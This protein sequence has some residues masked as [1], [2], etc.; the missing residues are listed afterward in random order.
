M[1]QIREIIG[2]IKTR[3]RL[4]I[5][6]CDKLEELQ[7]RLYALEENRKMK[8]AA[9]QSLERRYAELMYVLK[10]LQKDIKG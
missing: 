3:M 9:I 5:A 10:S 4:D 1:E 2:D 8:D 7:K 6:I